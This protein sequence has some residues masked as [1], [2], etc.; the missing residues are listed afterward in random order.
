MNRKQIYKLTPETAWETLITYN[1]TI[2][3]FVSEF[4]DEG[5]DKNDITGMAKRF[6]KDAPINLE[7]PLLQEDIDF[8]AELI[9][10]YIKSYIEKI[11]GIDKLK[12]MSHEELAERWNGW[13]ADLFYALE[14]NGHK[15]R[16]EK[17]KEMVDK[18]YSE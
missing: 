8:L 12:L 4:V 15:T 1:E 3:G 13:V 2:E 11:G 17:I 14:Q 10:K 16:N 9:E 5:Y 7:Q 18:K 6:V